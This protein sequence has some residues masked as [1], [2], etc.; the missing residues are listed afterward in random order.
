MIMAGLLPFLQ[1]QGIAGS[2][3]WIYLDPI[4]PGS[5]PLEALAAS[6][7]QHPAFHPVGNVLSFLRALTSDSSRS[8][9]LLARQPV[10]SSSRK[11]VLFIDQFEEIFT[12]TESEEERKRFF[13][14]LVIAATEPQGPLLVLLTLRADF[15]DRPMR[16][17]DLY[18][19][20]EA[21]RVTV[22]P[23]ERE[24]LRRVIV[25]PA[26]LPDVQLT[27]DDDLVGDLL[28]EVRDQGASLPLLQFTLDQLFERR[29]GHRLTRQAYEEIGGIKGAL[30]KHA[31]KTYANLP[32]E[33]HQKLAQTLF[34]RLIEPGKPCKR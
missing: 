20:L 5:H 23:M 27:F 24:D 13:D 10:G 22:L 19:L 34:V 3:E 33:E 21:H 31:E 25:E 16:Y 15:Y 6:L 8:L 9:S 7:A 29:S 17:R 12:L 2:Q 32:S 18:D 11:V 1:H 30:V 28:F 14:L 4:R 26:Q